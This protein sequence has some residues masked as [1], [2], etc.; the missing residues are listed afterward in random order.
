MT[1]LFA[2]LQQMK[3]KWP[4]S[5]NYQRANGQMV[6]TTK[7][8]YGLWQH[9]LREDLRRMVW[10]TDKALA[11]RKDMEGVKQCINY[12]ITTAIVRRS[13]ITRADE[14]EE[15]DT[16]KKQRSLIKS[17]DPKKSDVPI[18]RLKVKE[19]PFLRSFLQ[20][21]TNHRSQTCTHHTEA[22]F[23]ELCLVWI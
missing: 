10:A 11:E 15:D 18:P 23:Q 22:T 12:H 1:R 5:E 13:E 14:K 16:T 19:V 17:I 20:G 4:K 2:V 3:W 9:V 21:S 8:P 7:Q 6:S